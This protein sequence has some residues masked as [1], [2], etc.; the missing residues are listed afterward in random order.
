MLEAI[1]IDAKTLVIKSDSA[2][3]LSDIIDFIA[4]RDKKNKTDAFL[5]FASE[6]KKIEKGFKFVRD[7]CYDR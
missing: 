2:S 4:A 6:H 1:S 7:D 3:D 5:K